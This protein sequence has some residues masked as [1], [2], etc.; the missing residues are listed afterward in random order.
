MSNRSKYLAFSTDRLQSSTRGCCR[1]RESPEASLGEQGG[2]LLLKGLNGMKEG[3]EDGTL[4]QALC[5]R[6]RLQAQSLIISVYLSSPYPS[7]SCELPRV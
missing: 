4:L 2:G 6:Q 7:G 3:S 1:T 5:L